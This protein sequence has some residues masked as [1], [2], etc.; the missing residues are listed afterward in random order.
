MNHFHFSHIAANSIL[1]HEIES[2]IDQFDYFFCFRL[3]EATLP[4]I[5]QQKDIIQSSLRQK[6]LENI[7]QSWLCKVPQ[8]TFY[9]SCVLTYFPFRL[10]IHQHEYRNEMRRKSNCKNIGWE[11]EEIQKLHILIQVNRYV[12]RK[13]AHSY[14]HHNFLW[15]CNSIRLILCF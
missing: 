8:T 3:L 1:S 15:F 4:F 14:D 12:C 13:L 6:N 7:E 2:D 5:L 9:A 11:I 10:K